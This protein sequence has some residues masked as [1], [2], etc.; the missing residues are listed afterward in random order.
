MK[1]LIFRRGEWKIDSKTH[2]F[3]WREKG[4]QCPIVP[5][6]MGHRTISLYCKL[7]AEYTNCCCVGSEG[8]FYYGANGER[9]ISF[10]L[11]Q[12]DFI[13]NLDWIKKRKERNNGSS[14]SFYKYS[15]EWLNRRDY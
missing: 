12:T 7:H 9:G 4:C 15:S 10:N 11:N 1:K 5:N 14:I 13:K 3:F 8:R 6:E 2:P